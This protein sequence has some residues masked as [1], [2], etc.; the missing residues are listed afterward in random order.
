[1]ICLTLK[2]RESFFVYHIQS[3]E[4]FISQKKA[5]YGKVGPKIEQK[6]GF[7]IALAAVIS[8]SPTT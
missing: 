8:K 4:F 6:E 5:F 2:P 7:L 3:K 1:M